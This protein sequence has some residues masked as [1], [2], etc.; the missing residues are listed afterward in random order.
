MR[1]DGFFDV[2]TKTIDEEVSEKGVVILKE[3]LRYPLFTPTNSCFEGVLRRMNSF[4]KASAERYSKYAKKNLLR[5]LHLKAHTLSSANMSYNISY[6][7]DNY[8]CVIVDITGF[9]NKTTFSARFAH[10]WSVDSTMILPASHFIKTDR[11]SL[12]YIRSLLLDSVQK[13]KRNFS[14]GYYGDCEKKLLRAFDIRN[15]CLLPKGFAFFV[16]AGVLCDA[17]YGPCVFLL[18][19]EKCE[20]IMRVKLNCK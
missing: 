2:E 8:I 19:K 4:Y 18:P 13:N 5:K 15:F 3:T 11:K 6:C 12:S 9:D 17:S 16:D 10:T 1:K 14:F 20:E 7:D